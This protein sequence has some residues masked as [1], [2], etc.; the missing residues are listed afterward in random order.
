MGTHADHPKS[1]RA[2]PP[3]FPA[4]QGSSGLPV[5]C[6]RK[7]NNRSWRAH[8]KTNDTAGRDMWCSYLADMVD[9]IVWP[10][11]ASLQKTCQVQTCQCSCS[12][13]CPV[14]SGRGGVL[15]GVIGGTE[16]LQGV[17]ESLEKV[18]V[19]FLDGEQMV[20]ALSSITTA[21]CHGWESTKSDASAY[22]TA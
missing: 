1:C 15:R 12:A 5:S 14:G 18:R 19:V 21:F 22:G 11:K 10:N 6:R 20:K 3:C 13:A 7:Q 8:A 4:T 17:L 9:T 16:V 2:D